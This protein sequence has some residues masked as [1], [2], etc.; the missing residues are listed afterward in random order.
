MEIR[1]GGEMEG[2]SVAGMCQSLV[3]PDFIYRRRG[4]LR[5]LLEERCVC[6]SLSEL[7][8]FE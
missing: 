6:V 8:D 2:S 7:T 3:I 5:K 4:E 1:F